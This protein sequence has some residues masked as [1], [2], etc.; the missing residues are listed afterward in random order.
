MIALDPAHIDILGARL[1]QA[2]LRLA[3]FDLRAADGGFGHGG[4]TRLERVV[5]R[6]FTRLHSGNRL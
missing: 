2:R 3:Q 6:G 5:G 4:L 1:H